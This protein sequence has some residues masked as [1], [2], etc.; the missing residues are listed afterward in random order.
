MKLIATILVFV[1]I[2]AACKNKTVTARLFIM[3]G[4]WPMPDSVTGKLKQQF[5]KGYIEYF[6][7][8]DMMFRFKKSDSVESRYDL[9]V[10]QDNK[11]V[12]NLTLPM[13]RDCFFF[14]DIDLD[15]YLDLTF[16][17]YGDTKVYFFDKATGRFETGSLQF[18]YD[19][20][21]LDSDHHIYGANDKRD[22][23]YWNID[24]FSIVNTT[25][26]RMKNDLFWAKI[27]LTD[28][29]NNGGFEITRAMI[30]KSNPVHAANS[31]L[32][33]DIYIRKQFGDFSLLNFM[34]EVARSGRIV[35]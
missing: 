22:N 26:G 33:Q 9:Q 35:D 29:K 5:N 4:E 30:Y 13:P 18:P 3:P 2:L 17:E 34:K 31:T 24:I 15:K 7:V 8:N 20:A 10:S 12:T 1:C 28:N 6:S 16:I 23:N 25:E 32:V 21:L 11:W 19:Y 27:F 14:N